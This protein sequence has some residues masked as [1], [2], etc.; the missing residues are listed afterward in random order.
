M[1]S[2]EQVK[3]YSRKGEGPGEFMNPYT[4]G[5]SDAEAQTWDA[6]NSQLCRWS[7]TDGL[8]EVIRLVLSRA[9]ILLEGL[10]GAV[11]RGPAHHPEQNKGW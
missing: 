7:K 1:N 11:G 4:L 9:V 5:V 2:G 3:V 10:R 8:L 6:E